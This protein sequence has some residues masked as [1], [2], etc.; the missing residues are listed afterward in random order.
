MMDEELAAN[1]AVNPSSEVLSRCE[2][3]RTLGE[4][5]DALYSEMWMEIK[6]AG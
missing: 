4:E 5:G 1:Q 3:F 2:V 6:D